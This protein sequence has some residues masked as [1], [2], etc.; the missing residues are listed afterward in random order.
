M[1]VLV[2]GNGV[3]AGDAIF[4]HFA[5]VA[6]CLLLVRKAEHFETFETFSYRET[7]ERRREKPQHQQPWRRRETTHGFDCP[8]A[9]RDFL[10]AAVSLARMAAFWTPI[11]PV[12]V[13]TP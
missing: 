4:R 9:F 10:T 11:N 6:Q 13:T 3:L 8:L 12:A 1:L 5:T 7:E 2:G